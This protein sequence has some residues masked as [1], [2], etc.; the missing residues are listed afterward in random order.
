MPKQCSGS[1]VRALYRRFW[2]ADLSVN[3]TTSLASKFSAYIFEYWP[4][5]PYVHLTSTH[6]MNAP[7]PSPFFAS[8]LLQFIIVNRR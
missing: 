6:V 5:P 7:K 1:S 3:K 2:T 8:F 4:L